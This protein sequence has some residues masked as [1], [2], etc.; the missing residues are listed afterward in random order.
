MT[1]ASDVAGAYA[2]P[3]VRSTPFTMV[4][5]LDKGLDQYTVY[6]KDDTA[7]YATL[8]SGAL[9]TSTLNPGDRDGNSIRFGTTG[10]FNDIGEFVD[11][12]RIY[13]TD[14]SPIGSVTPVSLKLEAKS[15]GTLSLTNAT[16]SAISLGFVP[17]CQRDRTRSI[18]L[19]G[20]A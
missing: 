10:Q 2:L 15:D 7:P 8:G 18:L 20:T 19:V 4:L 14:T 3:L 12:S 9:G 16:S 11:I 6:Y 17:H 1:G 13:L 5:E